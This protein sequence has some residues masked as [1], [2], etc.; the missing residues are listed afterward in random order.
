MSNSFGQA[1]RYFRASGKAKTPGRLIAAVVYAA[2][3]VGLTVLLPQYAGSLTRYLPEY[4]FSGLDGTVYAYTVITMT[5][6]LI[7]RVFAN[8]LFTYSDVTDGHCYF[9]VGNGASATSIL[10]AKL[11]SGLCAPAVTYTVGAALVFGACKL[12]GVSFD[13]FQT[14]LFTAISG[15]CVIVSVNALQ[16]ILGAI[17]GNGAVVGIG[18]FALMFL[19]YAYMYIKNFIRP[20]NSAS[21]ASAAGEFCSF[22]LTGLLIPAIALTV[23]AVII[24]LTAPRN[25]LRKYS[26][27]D[28]D[29]DM[30]RHLSF[31][32]DLEVY[33]KND[34][35]YELLFAGKDVLGE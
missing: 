5:C 30:L 24:C 12:L 10:A 27:E 26:V 7:Y 25:K 28:L 21:I 20:E 17:G 1:F 29:T 33:E 11:F 13:S 14:A 23:L 2:L 6:L 9:A 22:S 18:G 31:Q 3:A 32:T 16:I 34:D 35:E 4:L 15:L 19:A 8:R